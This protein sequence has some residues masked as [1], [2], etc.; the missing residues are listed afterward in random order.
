LVRYES[1]K[2]IYFG[3]KKSKANVMRY[4]KQVA[5]DHQTERNSDA[6]CVRQLRWVFP[7]LMLLSTAGFLVRGVLDSCKKNIAGAGY[8][9]LTSAGFF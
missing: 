3:V 5:V 2:L 7:R 6:C 4:K 8:D 1:W 9:I